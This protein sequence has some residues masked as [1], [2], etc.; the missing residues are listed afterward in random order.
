M[1]DDHSVD[2]LRLPSFRVDGQL[3]LVTGASV[4]IGAGIAI[5]LAEAGAFRNRGQTAAM[6][7]AARVISGPR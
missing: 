1:R 6:A 3:A 7:S 5:A 2:R 4:G